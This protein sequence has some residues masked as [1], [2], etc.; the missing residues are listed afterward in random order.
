M[1]YVCALLERGAVEDFVENPSS[2]A[3]QR[4]VVTIRC[5]HVL[6]PVCMSADVCM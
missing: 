5:I 6:V 3:M 1:K 2:M 4:I